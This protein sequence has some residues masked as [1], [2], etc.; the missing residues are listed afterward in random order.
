MARFSKFMKARDLYSG[1]VI[2]WHPTLKTEGHA[3]EA[4]FSVTLPRPNQ[5]E[6]AYCMVFREHRAGGTVVTEVSLDPEAP[7]T[8]ELNEGKE[9]DPVL[10]NRLANYRTLDRMNWGV[11]VARPLMDHA[12]LALSAYC[13]ERKPGAVKFLPEGRIGTALFRVLRARFSQGS[14]DYGVRGGLLVRRSEA[15][16]GVVC[17]GRRDVEW[18][19]SEKARLRDLLFLEHD[20]VRFD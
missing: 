16:N 2:E 14:D 7:R 12:L 20:H 9:L 1:D 10:R 18:A 4:R 6:I 13:D 19:P 5:P 3:M 11:H 17:E 15:D 8:A